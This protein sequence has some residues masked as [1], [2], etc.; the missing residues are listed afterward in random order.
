MSTLSLSRLSLLLLAVMALSFT[1]CEDDDDTVFGIDL[2]DDGTLFLSS[3]T[4]GTVGVLNLEDGDMPSIET[5]T[6]DGVDADGIFYDTD[7]GNV[8]QINRSAN[9]VVEYN[10]VRDDLDDPNGVDVEARSDST[11]FTSGRGLANFRDLRVVVAQQGVDDINDG[12]NAFVVYDISDDDDMIER[13]LTFTTDIALWGIQFVGDDLY[14]V[15]DKSDSI[16]VFN[17]FLTANQDGDTI[18]PSRIFKVDGLVRTH[19]L[20]Y[21]DEDKVMVLTDI[22]DA[23][24]P[25]DG[26]LLVIR[27]FDLATVPDTL[28]SADYTR[29]GGA[30][31]QLGNPVDVEWDQEEDRIYVA[32]RANGGGTL[33]IFDGNAT[34]DVAPMRTISFPGLSSVYLHR[35]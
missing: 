17:D 13:T 21:N 15:V 30:S 29:I 8:Y 19:G 1:S 5:F 2:D 31:T 26:A 25:S 22:G 34:G 3:N 24:S 7:E 20:Q 27:D 18:V 6:A 23:A 28:T 9:T 32:E 33:L 11:D 16:A 35:D 14:A 10:D 12:Q 4:S